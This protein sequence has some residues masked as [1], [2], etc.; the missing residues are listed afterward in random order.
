MGGSYSGIGMNE[1]FSAE[2]NFYGDVEAA[3][4]VIKDFKNVVLIPIEL[5]FEY[6]SRDFENFFANQKT[7]VGRF[8]SDIFEG[9]VY[10]L[11]DPL[12]LFPIFFPETIMKVYE[13]Y[14]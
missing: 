9:T 14:A 11:C 7:E 4:I 13:V 10:V 8:I 6:P 12:I 2:F 3:H 5:A 1:T